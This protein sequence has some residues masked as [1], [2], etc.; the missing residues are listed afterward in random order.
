MI[1]VKIICTVTLV[2]YIILSLAE[3][4]IVMA[5][6]FDNNDINFTYAIGQVIWFLLKETV[7]IWFVIVFAK[8]LWSLL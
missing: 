3:N 2:F 4:A 7:N 6:R 8:M 5:E 1:V